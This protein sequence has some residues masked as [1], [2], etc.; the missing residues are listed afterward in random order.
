MVEKCKMPQILNVVLNYIVGRFVI[1]LYGVY[2]MCV[3]MWKVC[4]QDLVHAKD[5]RDPL[6]LFIQNEVKYVCVS[7]VLECVFRLI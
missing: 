2:C 3:Y 1:G 6:L 4:I 7:G 5:C